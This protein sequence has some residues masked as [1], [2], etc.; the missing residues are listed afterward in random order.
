MATKTITISISGDTASSV[1]LRS[2]KLAGVE[3][4][5][6]PALPQPF[7][8]AGSGSW[9]IVVGG[10]TAGSTYSYL[11][12]MTW[13]DSTYT[14]E[15][16]SFTVDTGTG[17]EWYYGNEQSVTDYASV[18][19]VSILSNQG[20]ASDAAVNSA[21]VLRDGLDSDA[22]FNI[23]LNGGPYVIPL[24]KNGTPLDELPDTDMD[25]RFMRTLSDSDVLCRL[26]D[27][28]MVVAPNANQTELDQMFGV[29]RTDVRATLQEIKAGTLKLN[30]DQVDGD[31]EIDEPGSFE[32]VPI[33][34]NG[35]WC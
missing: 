35:R 18:A 3:V 5:Q 27:H 29:V 16:G 7:T 30:C 34:R 13:A 4:T 23:R 32:S 8:D 24:Q 10:L 28:R 9:T 26:N 25:R 6:S 17:S 22:D 2:V 21:K 14:D 12:R 20:G 33:V 11:Y 19:D 31:D 1:S 15:E